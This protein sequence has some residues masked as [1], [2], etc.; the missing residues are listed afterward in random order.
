MLLQKG[1]SNSTVRYAQNGLRMMRCYRM[2]IDGNF[3]PGMEEAVRTF[4]S[5]FG[6]SVTGTVNDSTWNCLR[7]EITPIQKALNEK[8]YNPGNQLG[9]IGRAHV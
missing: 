3:G 2:E 1:D 5:Q 4:Q 7:V 9:E 6:L 8:G